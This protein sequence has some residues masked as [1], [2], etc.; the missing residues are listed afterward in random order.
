MTERRILSDVNS[1]HGVLEIV[2]GRIYQ[3]MLGGFPNDDN[4][5]LVRLPT[6]DEL[7][8]YADTDL[9]ELSE[10]ENTENST[11]VYAILTTMSV[12]EFKDIAK[13]LVS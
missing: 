4:V 13:R 6:D 12:E 9:L 11:E 5:H 2:S 3:E 10:A 1:K 7:D 8:G